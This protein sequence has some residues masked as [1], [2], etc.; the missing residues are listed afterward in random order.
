MDIEKLQTQFDHYVALVLEWLTG[1]MLYMQAGIIVLAVIVG[2]TISILVKRYSTL[3]MET[4]SAGR[5]EPIRKI[6][7]FIRQ[8]LTPLLIILALGVAA[9]LSQLI[10]EQSWP[11]RVA[12]SLAVI[13][14]QCCH[15]L[16]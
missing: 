11:I 2:Y 8:L 13:Y 5:W 4:P 9:Q 7:H 10:V 14:L 15:S 16:R 1:P 6:M 12:Q 3:L